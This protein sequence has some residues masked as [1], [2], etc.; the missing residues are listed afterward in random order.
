MCVVR[1]GAELPESIAHIAPD[2]FE[3]AFD[4]AGLA[5][6]L[7]TP[8]TRVKRALLDQSLISGVGNIDADEALWRARLHWARPTETLNG[9]EV[10]R[11]LAAVREVL[12]EALVAGGTS[13]DDLYVNVNGESGYFERS[14]AVYGREGFGCLRCGTPVRRDPFMNRSA[15]TCPRCQPRPRRA[16][17]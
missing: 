8:P 13:F 14:L 4:P 12:G 3:A 1:D 7:R 9:P 16:R 15:Y 2:P 6:R 10:S 17:L 11:L 5:R